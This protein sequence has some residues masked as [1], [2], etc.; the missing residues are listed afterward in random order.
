[1]PSRDSIVT[2][3]ADSLINLLNIKGEISL[4]EASKELNLPLKTVE[5]YANFFEEE[6]L[7]KIN[8][9]FTTPFLCVK[10]K[11]EKLPEIQ[12]S[13]EPKKEGKEPE[14]I[15]D[16]KEEIELIKLKT[17]SG[18]FFFLK[19][20]YPNILK[21]LKDMVNRKAISGASVQTTRMIKTLQD[22]EK[23]FHVASSAFSENNHN[24]AREKFE[25][26]QRESERIYQG[27][28]SQD[29]SE[30]FTDDAAKLVART[31]DIMEKGDYDEAKRLY[32]SLE[33]RYNNMPSDYQKRMNVL[34]EELIR[35]N[36]KLTENVKVKYTHDMKKGKEV[37]HS[38]MRSAL[39]NLEQKHLAKA[40]QDFNKVKEIY[41]RLPDGYVDEKIELN[42]EILDA[43]GKI[44]DERKAFL[45]EKFD[46]TSR[47]VTGKIDE[48]R[49][50]LHKRE[51]NKCIE[52]YNLA[53]EYFNRLPDVNTPVKKNLK[54]YLMLVFE[55]LSA[56]KLEF[57]N[58]HLRKDIEKIETLIRATRQSLMDNDLANSKKNYD[59]LMRVYKSIPEGYTHELAPTQAR[60]NFLYKQFSQKLEVESKRRFNE[61]MDAI[62]GTLTFMQEEIKQERH[63]EALKVYEKVMILFND[64]PRGYFN[65]K[66]D[67]QKEIVEMYEKMI[68]KLDDAVLK[69]AGQEIKDM[70]HTMLKSIILFY[71]HLEAKEIKL[72]ESDYRHINMLLERLPFGIL[73]KSDLIKK[74]IKKVNTE[75]FIVRMMKKIDDEIIAGRRGQ[76]KVIWQE[77][78]KQFSQLNSSNP[79]VRTLFALFDS[80]LDDIERD[81]S[82]LREEISE[83]EQKIVAEYRKLPPTREELKKATMEAFTPP[84]KKEIMA[85][86]PLTAI[87]EASMQKLSRE[88]KE[89]LSKEFD[90]LR[91]ILETNVIDTI[92]SKKKAVLVN[93][94]IELAKSLLRIE[95]FSRAKDLLEEALGIDPNSNEVKLLLGSI[96]NG[97]DN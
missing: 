1:M 93:N 36:S 74:E 38:F 29:I 30:T 82:E 16:I 43:Y 84:K 45:L 37:I 83:E 53:I 80:K 78:H 28:S 19:N 3:E 34:K 14:F 9:K 41:Y 96:T 95:K 91:K 75:I 64:L 32:Q 92:Y 4:E 65:E 48:I 17:K 76:A 33:E 89:K 62:K 68:R 52:T 24:L 23:E 56:A 49:A 7:L 6:G 50:Y 88:K 22:L 72:V 71:M 70:Y 63:E 26:L 42:E 25:F 87:E 46:S 15:K 10:K 97:K 90:E 69:G 20:V 85:I 12:F 51:F 5:D 66:S 27:L 44:S 18:E 39:H 60:M 86:A 73:K 31:Y 35:L 11:E 21:M 40:I 2:T 77:T 55:R 57:F 79:D 47:I 54:N 59:D 81:A 13:F 67:I 58:K 61:Q 8:Y 94:R